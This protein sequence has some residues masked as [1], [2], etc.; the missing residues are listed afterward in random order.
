MRAAGSRRQRRG[1]AKGPG[2][3]MQELGVEA[4]ADWPAGAQRRA[5]HDADAARTVFRAQTR[6]RNQTHR[7]CSAM[8]SWR[9]GPRAQGGPP[10]PRRTRHNPRAPD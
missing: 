8:G 10:A 5:F 7:A 2:T 9:G 3:Q 6:Q 4:Q 1:L